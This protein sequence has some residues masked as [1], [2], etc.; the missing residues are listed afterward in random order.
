M[1]FLLNV[2]AILLLFASLDAYAQDQTTTDASKPMHAIALHGEPKYP[3][4]FE[5]VDYVNPNAPKGGTLRQHVVGTFDSLNPFIVKGIPAAGLNYLRSGLVYESLMQNAWDEPF[6]LYG[7]IAETIQV[8]EDKSWVRFKIRDEAKWHDGKPITADDVIWTFETLTQKGQPFFKA[9]WGDVESINADD[10]KTVTFTFSVQGNAELPLIIAEMS[11][12]PKHYWTA[13]GRNFEET[14][15]DPPLGSGPYKISKVEPGRSIEYVRNPDWWGKDLA[16]FKGM[17][18]FD[19]LQY[20]YYRD[21][22]V[23]H[24]AFLS[25]DFDVKLESIAKEWAEGYKVPE[26][27]KSLL[28][29]EEIENSRPAGM[30]AFV[31]N[32]RRPLFQDIAVREAL[33]YAFDFEWANKQFAYGS[34]IRTNSFFENSELA[35]HE[36]PSEDELKILEPLRD[37]IPSQVFEQAYQA[38]VTDG[39]GQ[40]PR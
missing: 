20:D 28:N 6:T 17:N 21:E 19:R 12:L 22:N 11:V 26:A 23:A 40:Y 37:K 35:S 7:V 4:D 10:E 27:K 39:T 16:F 3:P 13:E 9:Y 25:Q 29:M 18:N 33:S 31:Y 2:T 30:Q 32:I 5:H 8:A 1:R 34:Y 15:L 36:M 14:T 38:P 24:E